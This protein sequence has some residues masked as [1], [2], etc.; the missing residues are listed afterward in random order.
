MKSVKE[1]IVVEG[2][3]DK[4][5]V[6][7][8]VNAT[9]M[10]TSGFGILKNKDKLSLLKK[11]AAKR[12]LIILTDSDKA[13]FFIRGR[14]RGLLGGDIKHAYIPDIKGRERR[15]TSNSAEGKLGV[16]GMTPDVI[17]EVLQR[18]GATFNDTPPSTESISSITKSD[19]F[20]AGLSGGTESALKRRALLKRLD[21]PERLPSN[22]FLEVINILF[23]KDE[24]MKFID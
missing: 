12:G 2:R 5:T 11:L 4:N 18:A 22:G 14:L 20:D 23:T 10:E 8:S 16:E 3:Y 1:V 7:Q 17:I 24:F 19:L 6:L 15:K 21:L 13:G 9:V